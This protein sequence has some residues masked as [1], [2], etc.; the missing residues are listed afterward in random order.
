MIDTAQSAP[1]SCSASSASTASTIRRSF[2][3]KAIADGRLGKILQAD[4]YVKWYRTAEYYS[5][6][7]KGSWE[8]EGGGALINQAVHQVDVLHWLVGGVS[9]VFGYWQLGATHKIESRRRRQCPDPLSAAAPPASSRPRP[10]SGPA[11]PSASRSTA[12]RAPRSSP[13]TS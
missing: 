1:A 13:A 11:T 2:V 4:A 5:R 12:P 10:P 7:I 8:T 9:E 6:P 3:K